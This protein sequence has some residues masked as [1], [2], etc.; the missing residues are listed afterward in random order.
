MSK[1]IPH[2][3]RTFLDPWLE[4]SEKNLHLLLWEIQIIHDIVAVPVL[5]VF[6]TVIYK[7]TEIRHPVFAGLLQELGILSSLSVISLFSAAIRLDLE[8]W[9]GFQDGLNILMMTFH[10]A[11]WM[12]ITVQRYVNVG[13]S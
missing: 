4:M 6:T 9:S 1:S 11:S 2:V 13:H 12:V 3:T 10:Q 7:T 5:L 8:Q